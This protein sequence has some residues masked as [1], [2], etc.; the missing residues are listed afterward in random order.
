MENP[1]QAP[2]SF[3]DPLNTASQGGDAESIRRAHIK[4]EAQVKSI[5]SLYWIGAIFT[6]IGL[7][8][9]PLNGRNA[10]DFAILSL[11]VCLVLLQ[12]V[13]GTGLRRLKPWSRI[14]GIVLSGIGLLAFPVGTV[15]NLIIIL[16]LASKKSGIIF[17]QDY[18]GVIAATPHVRYRTSKVVWLI[19]GFFVFF[20]LAIAAV[21]F[22]SVFFAH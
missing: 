11:F 3:D 4:H 8:A 5:G 14:A 12:I 15:I 7:F 16:I 22:F 19:L 1:Y 17:S 10:E 18:R 20:V 6:V 2:V 21:G 9:M 13:I